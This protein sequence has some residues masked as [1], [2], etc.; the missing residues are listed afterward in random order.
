MNKH[1]ITSLLLI[2]ITPAFAYTDG[3]SEVGRAMQASTTPR[4]KNEV[5]TETGC[6]L[7]Q[8]TFTRGAFQT[9]TDDEYL[10]T[11]QQAYNEALDNSG[12]TTTSPG[13]YAVKSGKVYECDDEYCH[14]GK[15]V[16]M[17]AN[18][19][20]DG[21]PVTNAKAYVCNTTRKND[22]WVPNT[23]Q[24]ITCCTDANKKEYNNKII[25]STGKYATH[26]YKFDGNSFE[27]CKTCQT[28]KTGT[29]VNNAAKENTPKAGESCTMNNA[30]TAKYKKVGNDLK[31]IATECNSNYYLV[32]NS[33]TQEKDGT[34][35]AKTYCGQDKELKIIAGDKTDLTCT[36]KQI[37]NSDNNT[38]E[39]SSETPVNTSNNPKV[40]DTCTTNGT[41]TATYKE[42]ENG[43]KCVAST[44]KSGFYLV[45]NA[46]GE[47][48]GWCTATISCPENQEMK[49]IDGTKTDR[50][51][52]D[53]VATTTD[54]NET[55]IEE[56]VETPDEEEDETVVT[57]DNEDGTV[58]T[59]CTPDST[60]PECDCPDDKIRE[61]DNT[62]VDETEMFKKAKAEMMNCHT[63]L[64]T[65]T[66][67]LNNSEAQ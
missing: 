15:V 65:Q 24:T 55:T 19:V 48:Q 57:P 17:P 32:E 62:C 23:N 51:C 61:V 59:E 30:K 66:E 36:D 58:A 40:G 21:K 67:Q 25:D 3:Y 9:I 44:C 53:K 2:L 54:N 14:K 52:V 4:T 50:S 39:P 7:N 47:S 1:I 6:G 26:Y 56:T 12:G 35:V 13:T 49:I 46:N 29:T 64:T 10:F 38:P 45:V 11:T 8:I 22:Q 42:M 63:Q 20:F 28:T 31:C 5:E 60:N 34:C 41:E 43:I 37:T 16:F 33:I 18:H 27:I